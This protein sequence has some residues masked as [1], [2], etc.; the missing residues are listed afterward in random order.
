M[1]EA[2]FLSSRSHL[3]CH[4]HFS[5]W[6]EV[7][8]QGPGFSISQRIR[9]MQSEVD[10]VPTAC[11]PLREL[12]WQHRPGEQMPCPRQGQLGTWQV[13]PS[14]WEALRQ[15]QFTVTERH[16]PIWCHVSCLLEGF[17]VLNFNTLCLPPQGK[18][19]DTASF[20]C[21]LSV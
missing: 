11:Q 8:P 6:H 3:F 16:R 14:T 15:K 21:Q 18:T 1:S 12:R 17:P 20:K 2:Q 4:Q 5:L 9:G 19:P 7:T 13:A 10:S